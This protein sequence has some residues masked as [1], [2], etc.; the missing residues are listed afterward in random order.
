MQYAGS[1]TLNDALNELSCGLMRTANSLLPTAYCVPPPTRNCLTSNVT[2]CEYAIGAST[3]TSAN[4]PSAPSAHPRVVPNP[5]IT[6]ERE[7]VKKASEASS[8][9][10]F[11]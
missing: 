4:G 6:A 3:G 2:R 1:R 11:Q 8:G 9:W 7:L 5:E 10:I